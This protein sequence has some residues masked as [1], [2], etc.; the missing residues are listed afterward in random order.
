MTLEDN[1]LLIKKALWCF[2]FENITPLE[3]DKQ[4]TYLY[5]LYSL[6]KKNKNAWESKNILDRFKA[7]KNLLKLVSLWDKTVETVV[8]SKGRAHDMLVI[9]KITLPEKEEY[10]KIVLYAKQEREKEMESNLLKNTSDADLKSKLGEMKT[11]F[12]QKDFKRLCP[13]SIDEKTTY[14]YAFYLLVQKNEQ[15]LTSCEKPEKLQAK[16]NLTALVS[17]WNKTVSTYSNINSSL[18]KSVIIVDYINLPE[19]VYYDKFVNYANAW[20]T[21]SDEVKTSQAKQTNMSREI[22]KRN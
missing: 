14:L 11:I 8:T 3:D 22:S 16:K 20:K 21:K 13:A 6:I 5:A 2:D 10:D 19:K 15:A 18:K 1:L 4:K 12:S 17:L 7:R 9:N